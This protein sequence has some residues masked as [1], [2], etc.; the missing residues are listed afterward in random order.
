MEPRFY[1]GGSN[2][3][4]YHHK[5]NNDC[6]AAFKRHFLASSATSL[7]VFSNGGQAS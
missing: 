2:Y 1:L 6:F 5:H 4:E 3:L 7:P